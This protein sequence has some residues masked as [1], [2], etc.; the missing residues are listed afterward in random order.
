MPT[1]AHRLALAAVVALA[2]LIV[3]W[4][5]QG[6]NGSPWWA[7]AAL[8]LA[9]LVPGMLGRRRNAYLGASFLS[10]VYLFHALVALVTQ[11]EAR[12]AATGEAALSI[13]LLVAAS[14]AA[15]WV[16]PAE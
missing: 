13:G 5:L 16:R 7:L 14:F 3:A 2:A 12:L 8:P 10:L 4:A 1:L 11:P 6:G 15:R 9:A